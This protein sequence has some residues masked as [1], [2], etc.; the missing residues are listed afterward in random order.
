MAKASK[1]KP[2][3]DGYHSLTPYLIVDDARRAIEFYKK[4]FDATELYRFDAPDG[5]IAHAELQIGNSRFMLA[6]ESPEMIAVSPKRLGGSP[7]GL[8]IYVEDVDATY[9]KAIAAGGKELRPLQNQFY[10]DRSGTLQ[11]PFGH[12]WTIS[13]HIE[14]V[15]VEE[16]K[17]RASSGGG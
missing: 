3:P 13:T 1:V 9:P 15:S 6:D 2:I 16:T 11:D 14:D 4:A 8:L 7:V 5:K 12:K 10:G 17:E